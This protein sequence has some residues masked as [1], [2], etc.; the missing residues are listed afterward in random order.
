M[1]DAMGYMI[2]CLV[3]FFQGSGLFFVVD[4]MSPSQRGSVHSR[5]EMMG[6]GGE[7]HRVIVAGATGYIG[8]QVVKE[9][10]RRVRRTYL[11]AKS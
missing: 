5:L 2:M 9:C 3:A 7:G 6:G 8:R 10:V 4:G 11:N 1:R